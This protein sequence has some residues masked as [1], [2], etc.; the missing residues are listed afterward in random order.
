MS[1]TGK[2]MLARQNTRM[3]ERPHIL[4]VD[5]EPNIR[6]GVRRI[7]E[8]E[9]YRIT[10]AGDGAAAP[11]V[12]GDDPPDV[13]LLDVMMPGM[14]GRDVC[15]RVREASHAA[16]VVYFTARA[17]PGRPQAL[18]ELRH[19]ADAFLAKPA[20]GR[21]IVAGVRG[22]LDGG[23]TRTGKPLRRATP[24]RAATRPS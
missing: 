17:E 14:D 15:R 18:R 7:L 19:Q 9:G 3:P 22:V 4:V 6:S 12:I 2:A 13:V 20:T 23:Q 16:R 21:E 10:T 24:H 5:D 11:N 8:K 1:S